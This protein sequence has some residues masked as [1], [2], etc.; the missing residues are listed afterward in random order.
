MMTA[1][2]TYYF[3]VEIDL[4]R[5]GMS[6]PAELSRDQAMLLLHW[7]CV[8]YMKEIVQRLTGQHPGCSYYVGMAPLMMSD[9]HLAFLCSVAGTNL[10]SFASLF[11]SM[12]AAYEVGYDSICHYLETMGLQQFGLYFLVGLNLCEVDNVLFMT[13]HLV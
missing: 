2:K 6:L 11:P 5:R 8:D 12:E 3:K 4:A 10:D 7:V 9:S 1:Q 13:S